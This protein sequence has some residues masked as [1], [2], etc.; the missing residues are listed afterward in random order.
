MVSRLALVY[1][2]IFLFMDAL[3][4]IFARVGFLNGASTW[5]FILQVGLSSLL[6]MCI[7]L[8]PFLYKKFLHL[9]RTNKKLLLLLL[10]ISTW[11]YGIGT[12]LSIAALSHT[13]APNVAFLM[14]VTLFF[15]VLWERIFLKQKLSKQFFVAVTF[16]AVGL[17]LLSTS[18]QGLSFK[19]GDILILAATFVWSIS[20]LLYTS[21]SPR[22]KRQSRMPSSA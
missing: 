15:I 17:F 1:I 16:S 19:K 14:Q 4:L 12:S 6:A 21:P 8:L 3:R 20:C 9:F 7:Y 18:G 13:I 11:H 10:A 2:L 5:S 22:D